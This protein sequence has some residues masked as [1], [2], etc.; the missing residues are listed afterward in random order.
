MQSVGRKLFLL[1]LGLVLAG[2]A[3]AQ[4]F[5]KYV[6][7]SGNWVQKDGRV[8]QTDAENGL[9]RVDIPVAQAGNM[10]Y[11]FNVR[12]E[13]GGEDNHGGFGMHLFAPA[14]GVSNRRS[15]GFGDSYLFW[16]NYDENPVSGDIPKGLS[17]QI[18]HST[19]N[20]KMDLV[21]SLDLNYMLPNIP[22]DV[23]S[24]IIPVTLRMNGASGEFRIYDPRDPTTY[25][26]YTVKLPQATGDWIALRTNSCSLSFGMPANQ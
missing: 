1:G 17:A 13:G 9:A 26:V 8:Y 24:M 21:D 15:W 5:P 10:E 23:L 20:W 2:G 22:A 12:F 16:I 18:Y 3:F 4:S 14:K 11:A 25:Y 7:A 19:K 6:V